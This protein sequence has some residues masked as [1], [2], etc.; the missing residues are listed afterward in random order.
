MEKGNTGRKIG[1]KNGEV[2]GSSALGLVV[3]CCPADVQQDIT[4]GKN[5]TLFLRKNPADLDV[6]DFVKV[7]LSARIFENPFI[8]DEVRNEFLAPVQEL[9]DY[10]KENKIKP[11]ANLPET[12]IE[13]EPTEKKSLSPTSKEI[14]EKYPNLLSGRE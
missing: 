6:N 13:K 9:I 11:Q 1:S 4:K 7:A 8:S 10:I 2:Q 3:R 5:V 12:K 14:L